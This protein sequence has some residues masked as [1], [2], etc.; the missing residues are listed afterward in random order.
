MELFAGLSI[1]PAILSGA[2]AA[3]PD[4]SGFAALFRSA[5]SGGG[6]CPAFGDVRGYAGVSV[7]GALPGMAHG[8]HAGGIKKR[9]HEMNDDE[10]SFHE[11]QG[12]NCRIKEETSLN[13]V[14]RLTIHGHDSGLPVPEKGLLQFLT[15]WRR[16]VFSG[17][18]F[19]CRFA[20]R[21]NSVLF[22]AN[23]QSFF[24]LVFLTVAP[25][26][27]LAYSMLDEGMCGEVSARRMPAAVSA[28]AA[29]G[30][31]SLVDDADRGNESDPV[32]A[33]SEMT[34]GQL[35]LMIR[36]CSGIVCLC[37]EADAARRLALPPMVSRN[38]RRFGTAFTVSVE[39]ARGVTTGVSAADR[40]STVRAAI[41]D[42]AAPDDLAR[43][44]H[45]FP[46]WRGKTG[47]CPVAGIPKAVSI[48]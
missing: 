18:M 33:A 36:S 25:C 45:V 2:C 22:P 29:G 44:G 39:A 6:V 37:M 34:V 4:R 30:G 13:H 16:A 28:L 11:A 17:F 12:A 3:I 20:E 27:C 10:Y 1:R 35:A 14:I 38:T 15:I 26:V 7:N 47:C 42:G 8:G 46:P 19:A 31:V 40:L 5:G 43:P 32:S 9:P 24:R 21:A 41:A 48:R 23:R